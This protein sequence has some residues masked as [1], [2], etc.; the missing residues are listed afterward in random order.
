MLKDYLEYL[1]RKLVQHTVSNAGLIECE[2]H[3]TSLIAFLTIENCMQS[4]LS[5]SIANCKF[6][7]IAIDAKTPNSQSK[8]DIQYLHK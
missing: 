4:M 8:A 7:P 5:L 1:I 2:R 6:F 3:R